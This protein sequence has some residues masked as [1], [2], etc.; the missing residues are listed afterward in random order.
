MGSSQAGWIIP[1]VATRTNK[2]AFAV[3]RSSPTVTVAQHNFWHTAAKDLSLSIDELSLQIDDYQPPASGDFDPIPYLKKMAIPAIWLLGKQDRIIPAPQSAQ[4][5]RDIA[6][7]TGNPFT[8]VM[9]AD[10]DHGLRPP[11]SRDRVDYWQDLLPW[12]DLQLGAYDK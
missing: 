10:A 12:L 4:I 1:M 7:E 11:E 5:V 3:L 2:L 6:A 8:I 9:Y